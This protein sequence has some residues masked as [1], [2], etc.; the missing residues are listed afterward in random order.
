[1][2]NKELEKR[3]ED[4]EKQVAE[5]KGQNGTKRDKT[6]QNVFKVGDRVQ[7][8]SVEGKTIVGKIVSI[9]NEYASIAEDGNSSVFLW[10]IPI[11][12]L[13]PAT[14]EPKFKIGDVVK[15]LNSANYYVGKVGE[16]KAHHKGID[17]SNHYLVELRAESCWYQEQDLELY[18]EPKCKFK[19][20]DK[21]RFTTD[22][23]NEFEGTI[24][25]ILENKYKVLYGIDFLGEEMFTYIEFNNIKK[26]KL[27]IM[28]K[29]RCKF[30]VGDRVKQ[31]NPAEPPH[32]GDTGTIKSIQ[33]SLYKP[34]MQPIYMVKFDN[35]SSVQYS[36]QLENNLE[37]YTEPRWTFTDD[38]KV[39]LRNL[40][41]EYKWIARDDGYGLYIYELKPRKYDELWDGVSIRG[42]KARIDMFD[43]IFQS[44]KWTDEEPCEF[45]KYL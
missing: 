18:V 22:N 35:S 5:L 43:R 20:G 19:V 14:D 13:K 32:F 7:F 10:Y 8:V 3:V 29:S 33:C 12:Q 16:V 26:Q 31:V 38:E 40:P 24:Y 27:E 11:I 9:G 41:E 17:N 21:V 25:D 36:E 4:L 44:I 39:I 15:I 2:T 1:M 42:R 45:R 23:G 30:A 34:R 28:D 37:L 6:G